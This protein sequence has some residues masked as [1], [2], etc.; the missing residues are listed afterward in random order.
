MNEKELK[1]W[2][3]KNLR[4]DVTIDDDGDIDVKLM[5]GDE[6]VSHDWVVIPKDD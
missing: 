2:I 3:K 6:V 4:V 1:E 5:M